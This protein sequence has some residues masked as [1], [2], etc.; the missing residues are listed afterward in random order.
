MRKGSV[1]YQVSPETIRAQQD[2][3]EAMRLCQGTCE[4]V[5]DEVCEA[6]LDTL[7]LIPGGNRSSDAC[8]ARASAIAPR[9]AVEDWRFCSCFCRQKTQQHARIFGLVHTN[10]ANRLAHRALLEAALSSEKQSA[11]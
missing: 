4:R 6:V 3:M 8:D 7:V 2:P 9:M 10:L 5:P 11:A 1:P